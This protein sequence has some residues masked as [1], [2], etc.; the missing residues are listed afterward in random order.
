MWAQMITVR[1]K[2]GADGEIVRI[3]EMLRGIEQPDSGLIRHLTFRDQADP[4]LIRTLALF[5]S[6]EKARAREADPRRHEV[7]GTA[8]ALMAQV[9]DEPPVFD[10]LEVL[11]EFT[12]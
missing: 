6:E 11:M 1:V 3:M 5:E 8:Q 10:N 7:Q 9:I 4:Q 12:Y 2:E